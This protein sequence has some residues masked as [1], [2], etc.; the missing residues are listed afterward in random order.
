MTYKII[1]NELFIARRV[2]LKGYEKDILEILL[3]KQ[4]DVSLV[5]ICN[6]LGLKPVF[7]KEIIESLKKKVDY[8]WLIS[9]NNVKGW[10]Y[11]RIKPRKD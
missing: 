7:A 11:Y 9:S 4:H 10:I 8:N 5:K 2:I 6:E 3:K 1:N